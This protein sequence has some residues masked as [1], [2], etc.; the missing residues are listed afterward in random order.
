MRDGSLWFSRILDCSWNQIS[1]LL[2]ASL[3][4]MKVGWSC[5]LMRRWLPNKAFALR[6]V[7]RFNCWYNWEDLCWASCFVLPWS[8]L[9]HC[10][11]FK[12]KAKSFDHPNN[13]LSLVL[14]QSSFLSCYDL[15]L[16]YH[17]LS[18]FDAAGW[19]ESATCYWTLTCDQ[20]DSPICSNLAS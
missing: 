9:S 14:T 17:V 2:Q 10:S 15:Y 13:Y 19:E 3:I 1:H 12:L 6:A 20:N 16:N 4:R 5:A 7:Y 18:Q 8:Q 11:L